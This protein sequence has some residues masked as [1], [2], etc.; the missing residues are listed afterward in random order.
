MQIEKYIADKITSLCDGGVEH[1]QHLVDRKVLFGNAAD[2]AEL[3]HEVRLVL[4]AARSVDDEH[5]GR[6]EEHTSELQS[7]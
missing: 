4:Q 5:V 7:H 3:V 1:E 6:S 2:L